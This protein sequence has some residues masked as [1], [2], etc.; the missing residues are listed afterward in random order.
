MLRIIR[1]S[2]AKLRASVIELKNALNQEP[3]NAEGRWL[4]AQTY[5]KLGFGAE[6]EKELT[7]AKELGLKNESLLPLLGEAWI[8]QGNY[9]RVLDK[10]PI[11]TQSSSKINAR[12]AHLRG[13][14]NLR[15]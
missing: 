10:L 1:V 12:N 8:L 14:A 11:D 13:S 15:V 5:L 2:C 6:A 9:Q 4:L 7:K 3:N